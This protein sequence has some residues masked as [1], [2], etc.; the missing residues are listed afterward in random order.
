MLQVAGRDC[1]EC[2][3]DGTLRSRCFLAMQ[4]SRAIG[5][6]PTTTPRTGPEGGPW[7]LDVASAVP[8]R[9]RN[10]RA[11]GDRVDVA[12]GDQIPGLIQPPL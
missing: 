5:S 1:G 9:A 3:T 2:S 8:S 6:R 7:E 12:Y 10:M 4:I 11:G